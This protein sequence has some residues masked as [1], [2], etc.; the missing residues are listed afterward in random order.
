VI[1]LLFIVEVADRDYVHRS[2][3]HPYI[4]DI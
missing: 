3:G 4:Y 2:L 1:P